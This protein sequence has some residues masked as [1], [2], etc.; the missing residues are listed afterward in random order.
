MDWSQQETV[1]QMHRL[2]ESWRT[3]IKDKKVR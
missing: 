3:T 2:E 1:D